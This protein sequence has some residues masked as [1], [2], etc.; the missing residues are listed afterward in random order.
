LYHKLG[1]RC[2]LT[3]LHFFNFFSHDGKLFATSEFLN[4][5]I[6]KCKV[7][8]LSSLRFICFF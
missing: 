3:D 4:Q 1:Y 8:P 6:L 2:I 5:I 7:P